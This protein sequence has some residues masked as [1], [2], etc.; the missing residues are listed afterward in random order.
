MLP[1]GTAADLLVTARMVLEGDCGWLTPFGLHDGQLLRGAGVRIGR[2]VEV[3]GSAAVGDVS[4]VGRDVRLGF[5]A[6]IGR[7][8]VIGAGARLEDCVV[9]DDCEV[10]PGEVLSGV[11]RTPGGD[12]RAGE[13]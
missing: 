9:L 4:S 12:L 1:T 7:R 13:A 6:I 8:C 10:F 3:L 5:G 2:G 11:V